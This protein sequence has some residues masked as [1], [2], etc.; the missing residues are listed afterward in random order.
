MVPDESVVL[1]F[2]IAALAI[3]L[4]PGPNM[5]WLA[6]LSATAGRSVGFAAV[7]GITLGLTL[8]ALMAA[9]GVAALISA[10]PPLYTMLHLTGVGYLMWLGWESWR[11]AGRPA[12]HLDGGGETGRDGFRRG[13]IG[14]I[15]NP[16]AAVFF[17]TVLPGFLR[18]GDGL[19]V[20]LALSAI[21]LAVATCIHTGI[22]AVSGG[23]RGWLADP[24]ASVVMHRVQ[25]FAMI[26]VAIWLFVRG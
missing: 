3:E 1:S 5:T 18:P 7:V 8:Q 13:L 24:A 22:V 6:L 19:S 17:V 20:T 9:I 15:L 2:L 21:Y 16:K 23:L 4:T 25:A 14:N 11:D 10:W 12:H 26:G